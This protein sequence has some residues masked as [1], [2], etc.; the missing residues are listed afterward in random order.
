[1]FEKCEILSTIPEG[2]IIASFLVEEDSAGAK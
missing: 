2:A 1:M